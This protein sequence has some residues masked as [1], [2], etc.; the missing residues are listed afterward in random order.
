MVNFPTSYAAPGSTMPTRAAN[1]RRIVPSSAADKREANAI[2][3]RLTKDR[4]G[5]RVAKQVMDRRSG[6]ERR[7]STINFSV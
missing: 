3:R 7:R 4:R 6:S 1:Q 5:G 2:D